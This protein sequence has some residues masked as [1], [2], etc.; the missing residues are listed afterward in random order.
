MIDSTSYFMSPSGRIACMM[1]SPDDGVLT[2][3]WVRC[4]Y[5]DSDRAWTTPRPSGCRADWGSSLALLETA[6]PGCVY[7]TIYEGAIMHPVNQGYQMWWHLGDPTVTKYGATLAA[8]PY[9]SA[10]QVGPVRCQ[11]ATTAV[12]CTNWRTGHG[13][14]VSQ[15]TYGMF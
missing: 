10:I 2:E 9:G 14:V 6:R 7:Q 8:L 15:A 11:M 5:L 4:D 13:I 12:T 3:F 1:I